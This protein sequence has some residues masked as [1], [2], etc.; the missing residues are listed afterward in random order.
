M[1]D[2]SEER[3]EQ[4]DRREERARRGDVARLLEEQV[5]VGERPAAERGVRAKVLPERIGRGG[6]VD[7]CPQE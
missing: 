2:R 1:I 7:V 3:G 5:Q 6:I 4:R